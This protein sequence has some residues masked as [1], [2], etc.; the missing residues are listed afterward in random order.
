MSQEES[1][2][3]TVPESEVQ[4]AS[5]ASDPLTEVSGDL[6]SLG[7][8]LEQSLASGASETGPSENS[9]APAPPVRNATPEDILGLQAQ[10]FAE[11]DRPKPSPDAA[12]GDEADAPGEKHDGDVRFSED[13]T[14]SASRRSR[15]KLFGR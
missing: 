3:E 12:A 5:G 1:A 10:S 8:E 13:V 11:M 7:R 4:T 9:D 14:I 6:D 2:P 15:R